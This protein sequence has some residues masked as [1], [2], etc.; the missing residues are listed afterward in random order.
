MCVELHA[1]VSSSF[2]RMNSMS[3]LFKLSMFIR[4]R[5]SLLVLLNVNMWVI[6]RRN[7]FISFPAVHER[8]TWCLMWNC[9][10]QTVKLYRKQGWHTRQKNNNLIYLTCS[11]EVN[12]PQ[13]LKAFHFHCFLTRY[14][15]IPHLAPKPW[16]HKSS[17]AVYKYKV[18]LLKK[19]QL[20]S[21][22]AGHCGA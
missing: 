2:G 11:A 8:R 9:M 20:L 16:K 18:W 3:A 5:I 14:H 19:A 4:V 7:V 22:T 13:C 12:Y 15:K 1:A 17:K 21:K 10:S 6:V